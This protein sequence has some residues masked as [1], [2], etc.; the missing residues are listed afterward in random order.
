M[1]LKTRDGQELPKPHNW[2][3]VPEPSC[4]NL[5]IDGLYDT[6]MPLCMACQGRLVMAEIAGLDDAIGPLVI[7]D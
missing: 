1:Q 4:C 3:E 6:D 7:V 5:D 2:I